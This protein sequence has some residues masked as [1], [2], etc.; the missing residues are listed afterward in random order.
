MEKIDVV[1]LEMN[2]S[3]VA[4]ELNYPIVAECDS[5]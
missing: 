1:E 2:S 4:V 3:T 5:H